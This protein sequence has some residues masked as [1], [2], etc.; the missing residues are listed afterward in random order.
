MIY[1]FFLIC[2]LKYQY[3]VDI[4]KKRWL[5]MP[6]QTL[7]GIIFDSLKKELKIGDNITRPSREHVLGPGLKVRRWI[8]QD[9]QP[10]VQCLT[11]PSWIGHHKWQS[12]DAVLK[13][14]P[15]TSAAYQPCLL[16]LTKMR[17]S[18]ISA[19]WS[20]RFLLSKKNT[21]QQLNGNYRKKMDKKNNSFEERF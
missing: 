1:I 4:Q 18:I 17:C 5:E 20:N 6:E 9:S 16:M 11:G 14:A 19:L 3:T 7:D 8:L 2:N 15:L 12:P 10:P 13:G 21:G